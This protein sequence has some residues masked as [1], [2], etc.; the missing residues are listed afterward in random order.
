LQLDLLSADSVRLHRDCHAVWN[1]VRESWQPGSWRLISREMPP[2]DVIVEARVELREA[3]A[4]ILNVICLNRTPAAWI[5][6]TTGGP[7]PEGWRPFEW[8]PLREPRT[9]PHG[10]AS[11]GAPE[12]ASPSQPKRA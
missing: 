3:R 10:E 11:R 2:F 5:N 1:E 12:P 6:A 4:I 8:R 9:P 7:L